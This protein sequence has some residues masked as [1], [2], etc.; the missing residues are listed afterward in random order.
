MLFFCKVL[1]ALYLCVC[2]CVC[3]F[4]RTHVKSTNKQIY[5][6]SFDLYFLLMLP[7]TDEKRKTEYENEANEAHFNHQ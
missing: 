6:I 3:A 7:Q 1:N 5:F 2:V 4:K